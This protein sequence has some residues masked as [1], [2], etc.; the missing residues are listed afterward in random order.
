MRRGRGGGGRNVVSQ[1]DQLQF[2][3]F[4][5]SHA[6]G[7]ARG[8]IPSERNLAAPA[9]A[10]ARRQKRRNRAFLS[11]KCVNKIWTTKGGEDQKQIVNWLR[12]FGNR[13]TS[14]AGHLSSLVC[15]VFFLLHWAWAILSE[16]VKTSVMLKILC[17]Q[18]SKIQPDQLDL[19]RVLFPTVWLTE[20]VLK[21]HR[22]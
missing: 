17:C 8:S 6:S 22:V 7:G 4:A 19:S 5:E 14:S 18:R 2:T 20:V 11:L 12:V 21:S 10:A 15:L 1:C 16:P 9:A 13:M 3:K